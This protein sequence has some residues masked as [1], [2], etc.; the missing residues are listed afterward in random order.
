VLGHG[1]YWYGEEFRPRLT[2]IDYFELRKYPT[3]RC[4]K[5]YVLRG[6]FIEQ[7]ITNRR[8]TPHAELEWYIPDEQWVSDIDYGLC[9][10]ADM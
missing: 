1:H 2:E 3:R 9:I 4:A 10:S 8:R 5:N 7:L 6:F